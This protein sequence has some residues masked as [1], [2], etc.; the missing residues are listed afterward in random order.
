MPSN[1]SNAASDVGLARSTCASSGLSSRPPRASRSGAAAPRHRLRA[2][3]CLAWPR[4][5]SGLAP[6]GETSGRRPTGKRFSAQVALPLAPAIAVTTSAAST[7]SSACA[8]GGTVTR[9]SRSSSKVGRGARCARPRH[10]HDVA[11]RGLELVPQTARIRP[12]PPPDIAHL[13]GR[14]GDGVHAGRRVR[15][16]LPAPRLTSRGARARWG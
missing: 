5:C 6:D 12:S 8:R 9:H 10:V 13:D 2:A 15:A 14:A 11:G 16:V 4:R 3:P 1:S 7:K